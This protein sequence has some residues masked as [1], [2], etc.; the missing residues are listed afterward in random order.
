ML[1]VHFNYYHS[2]L[3]LNLESKNG[4]PLLQDFSDGVTFIYVFYM[5]AQ[6]LI[7]LQWN[8]SKGFSKNRQNK[9]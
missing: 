2:D 8:I 5:H 1:D 4:L 9:D 3:Y 7:Y 6:S